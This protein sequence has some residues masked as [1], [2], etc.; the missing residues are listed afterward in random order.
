MMSLADRV[1]AGRYDVLGYYDME[2]T[3]G[4]HDI[5]WHLDPVHGQRAP[6]AF[7]A[8]VPYLDASCGDHKVIWELNRHQH[9]LQ[10]VRASWLTGD[11]RYQRA[12]VDRLDSWLAANP[13]LI[14]INW[15][16]MLEIGFR[17]LSWTWALHGLLATPNTDRR[18]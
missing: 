6:A 11:P 17:S 1:L 9:W 2:F 3:G 18:P 15:A 13:P 14:G 4:A 16:S 10:L 12:I 7:W 8:D 5:D